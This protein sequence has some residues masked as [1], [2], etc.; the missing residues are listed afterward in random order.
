[1]GENSNIYLYTSYHFFLP[2]QY[3]PVGL[4]K[5]VINTNFCAKLQTLFPVIG[6]E[7][8][9]VGDFILYYVPCVKYPEEEH[10]I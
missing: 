8:E 1:M 5:W 10:S 3:I 7:S 9:N 4:N 2:M 6:L